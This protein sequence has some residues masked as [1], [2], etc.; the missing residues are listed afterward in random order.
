MFSFF[1][2]IRFP[3]LWQFVFLFCG[4]TN[5]DLFREVQVFCSI[6]FAVFLR[7]SCLVSF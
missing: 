3:F 1:V 4:K 2:A 7:I 6:L 5:I